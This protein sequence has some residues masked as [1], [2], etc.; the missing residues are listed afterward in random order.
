MRIPNANA[1]KFVALAAPGN[2]TGITESATS[3]L[4]E[5][6]PSLA[7]SSDPGRFEPDAQLQY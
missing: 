1:K 5:L 2:R 4:Q 7:A 3:T 6:F